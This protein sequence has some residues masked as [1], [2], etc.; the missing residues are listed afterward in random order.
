MIGH[1]YHVTNV[2]NSHSDWNKIQYGCVNYV[3]I[4]ELVFWGQVVVLIAPWCLVTIAE[5]QEVILGG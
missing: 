5:L 3:F 1:W 4:F 2:I